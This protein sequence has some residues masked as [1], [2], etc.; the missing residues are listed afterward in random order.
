[1]KRGERIRSGNL[2]G[3]LENGGKTV[4]PE[5]RELIDAAIAKKHSD[6]ATKSLPHGQ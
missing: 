5:I 4:R 1:M 3:L 2:P 6:D